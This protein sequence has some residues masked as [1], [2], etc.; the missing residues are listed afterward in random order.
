MF[1]KCKNVLLNWL[2]DAIIEYVLKNK[3]SIYANYFDHRAVIS[4]STSPIRAVFDASNRTIS[5]GSKM[6]LDNFIANSKVFMAEDVFDCS[7]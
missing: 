2:V 3:V 1:E 5:L 7:E 6:E 4:S